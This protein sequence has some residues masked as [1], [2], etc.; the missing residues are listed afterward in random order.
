MTVHVFQQHSPEGVGVIARIW[1][2]AVRKADGDAYASYMRV[3][4]IPGYRTAS[5]HLPPQLGRG[6]LIDGSVL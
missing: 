1:R 2:G 4:G 6:D 5:D 3:T